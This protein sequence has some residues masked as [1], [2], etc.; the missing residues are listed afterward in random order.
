MILILT[1]IFTRTNGNV[2]KTTLDNDYV[3][4]QDHGCTKITYV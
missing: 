1:N 2:V 3:L 4:N